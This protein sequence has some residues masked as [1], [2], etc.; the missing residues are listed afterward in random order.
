MKT[1]L[2]DLGWLFLRFRTDVL[3]PKYEGYF[4]KGYSLSG[5][6]DSIIILYDNL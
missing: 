1:A 6:I 5:A 2:S 3:P 4:R